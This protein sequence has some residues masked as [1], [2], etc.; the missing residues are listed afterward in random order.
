MAASSN[1]GKEGCNTLAHVVVKEGAYSPFRAGDVA[2]RSTTFMAPTIIS[3]SS[4]RRPDTHSLL[5]GSFLL[6]FFLTVVDAHHA[7]PPHLSERGGGHGDD[8]QHQ[9]DIGALYWHQAMQAAEEAARDGDNSAVLCTPSAPILRGAA[10]TPSTPT[11]A[12]PKLAEAM[13]G[14]T[15]TV[16]IEHGKR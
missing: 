2:R 14:W 4:F 9:P 8:E 12:P 16:K 3:S 10:C 1:K 13:V 11:P 5:F 6:G 7:E 15:T